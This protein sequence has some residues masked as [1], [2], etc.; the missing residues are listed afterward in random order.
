VRVCAAII[1]FAAGTHALTSAVQCDQFLVPAVPSY[2]LL[3]VDAIPKG[4][5]DSKVA[6]EKLIQA[7]K[8]GGPFLSGN[9]SSWT[10]F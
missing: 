6:A 2:E 3:A 4:F 10:P 8:V 9:N 1:R 5:M 7:L